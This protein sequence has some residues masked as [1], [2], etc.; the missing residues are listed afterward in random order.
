MCRKLN[1]GLS[2]IDSLRL[3]KKNRSLRKRFSMPVSLVGALSGYDCLPHYFLDL[4]FN[5]WLCPTYYE[6]LVMHNLVS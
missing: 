1:R 5:L 6:F 4:W 2:V 3:L